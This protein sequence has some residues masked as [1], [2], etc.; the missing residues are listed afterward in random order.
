MQAAKIANPHR[1]PGDGTIEFAEAR[2]VERS[3]KAQFGRPMT[4][5]DDQGCYQVP[6][7]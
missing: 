5:V 7:G 2:R 6:A 3:L 1:S 4:S